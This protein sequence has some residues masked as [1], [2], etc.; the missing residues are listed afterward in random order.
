MK[1]VH[2]VISNGIQHNEIF[3]EILYLYSLCVPLPIPSLINRSG[4]HEVSYSFKDLVCSTY[5]IVMVLVL[6]R[7]VFLSL[8]VQYL[9]S[10]LHL[11]KIQLEC[12]KYNTSW[13]DN[14]TDWKHI[15]IA[16]F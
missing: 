13:Y 10:Q 3:D 12:K 2:I 4:I 9:L 1:I 7:Q 6:M 15:I 5:E 8:T 14:N 11:I 16:E